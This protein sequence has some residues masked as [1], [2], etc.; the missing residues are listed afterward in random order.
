MAF[1]DL[2]TKLR[3]LLSQMENQPED[4]HELLE[5]LHLGLN[6]LRAT[7]RSLPEDLVQLERSLEQELLDHQMEERV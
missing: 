3:L 5:Q 4:A 2:V 1:E 7:G 6:Q